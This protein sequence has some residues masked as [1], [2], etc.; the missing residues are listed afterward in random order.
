MTWRVRSC[1]YHSQLRTGNVHDHIAEMSQDGDA[2]LAST[3]RSFHHMVVF[4]LSDRPGSVD[5]MTGSDSL[6][7]LLVSPGDG[8]RV[9]GVCGQDRKEEPNWKAGSGRAVGRGRHSR[10]GVGQALLS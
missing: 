7:V 6:G 9:K 4:R 10:L 1:T 8:E 3:H 2:G 5:I